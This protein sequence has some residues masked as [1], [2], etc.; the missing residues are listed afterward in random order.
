[1]EMNNTTNQDPSD[2]NNLNQVIQEVFGNIFPSWHER[3][4]DYGNIYRVFD[5][6]DENGKWVG[7][8]WNKRSKKCSHRFTK[9]KKKLVWNILDRH[10]DKKN[11][12]KKEESK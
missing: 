9:N 6:K 1:M 10:F 11:A 7:E 8:I 12:L 4:D 3:I 5:K 2:E